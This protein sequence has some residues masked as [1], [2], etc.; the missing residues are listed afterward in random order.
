MSDL[1]YAF[2]VASTLAAGAALLLLHYRGD[3]DIALEVA[4]VRDVSL[5][6]DGSSLVVACRLPLTNRGSR[7]GT[8]VEMECEVGG[9]PGPGRRAGRGRA[10]RPTRRPGDGGGPGSGQGPGD[11][12]GPGSAAGP[13]RPWRP[14]ALRPGE[15]VFLQA[16]AV[17]TLPFEAPEKAVGPLLRELPGLSLSLRYKAIGRRAIVCRSA[18]LALPWEAVLGD[19]A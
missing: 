7:S 4:R 11:G 8:V 14:T 15:T 17:L 2:G 10:L 1:L 19:A 18:V 12:P 5:R 6:V 9:W 3:C 13:P 16:S